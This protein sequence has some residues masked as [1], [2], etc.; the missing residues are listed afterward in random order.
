MDNNVTISTIAMPQSLK[1]RKQGFESNKLAKRL[2]RLTGQTEDLIPLAA[3]DRLS[4][5]EVKAVVL[6]LRG[7]GHVAPLP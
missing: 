3:G 4:A 2:R 1:Q 5:D 6:V 7:V